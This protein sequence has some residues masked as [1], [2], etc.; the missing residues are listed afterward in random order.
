MKKMAGGR[1]WT[2]ND[3]AILTKEY[4]ARSSLDSIA[5][6]LGRT[7]G[8]V[9]ARAQKLGL[10]KDVIRNNNA[11]YKA[12]YQDY[13]WLYQKVVVE[14][15]TPSEIALETGFKLRTIEKWLYEKHKISNRTIKELITL[16]DKQKML[17]IAGTLGDGH[18]PQ[19]I[20]VYIE[21]H[22][23]DEKGYLKYKY[24]ILK[25]I[26]LKEPTVRDGCV[27]TIK[28]KLCNIKP[29]YRMTTREVDE[30]VQIRSMKQIDK[31][32]YL[33]DF[34]LSLH[35]LDDGSRSASNWEICVAEW[36]DEEV[37]AYIEKLAFFGITAHR[38]KDKRYIR[39]IGEGTKKCDEMII[40]NIPANIDIINKKFKNVKIKPWER[41]E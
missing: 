37:E 27:K 21:S 28:G 29:S 1:E 13:N 26:N 4:Y 16:T 15:K 12:P 19:D 40:S 18:I 23:D 35:V 33:D 2:S 39:T 20:P 10:T 34:G 14:H 9:S 36:T 5:Q 25:N 17:I 30:L 41:E 38:C 32:N 24:E 8:A 3:D 11:N 7:Y 6:K 22:A 31:I